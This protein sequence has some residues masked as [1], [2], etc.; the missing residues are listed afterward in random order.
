MRWRCPRATEGVEDLHFAPLR[1]RPW[2]LAKHTNDLSRGA[3]NDLPLVNHC[4]NNAKMPIL[5]RRREST[6]PHFRFNAPFRGIC[7]LSPGAG[8]R[9]NGASAHEFRQ[10]SRNRES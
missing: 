4:A 2:K 10:R 1:V 8:L 3:P 7:A 5:N 6:S 9:E